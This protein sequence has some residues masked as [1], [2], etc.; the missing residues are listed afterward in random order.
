MPGHPQFSAQVAEMRRWLDNSIGWR[1]TGGESVEIIL[2]PLL[3]TRL[4]SS[5]SHTGAS[6]IE[7]YRRDRIKL[8]ICGVLLLNVQDGIQWLDSL[9]RPRITRCNTTT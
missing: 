8:D 7:D 4:K 3:L 6:R 9:P 2:W 1:R 5:I